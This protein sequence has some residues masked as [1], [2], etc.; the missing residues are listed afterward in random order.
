VLKGSGWLT[1][2]AKTI[3]F[4]KARALPERGRSRGATESRPQG[5]RLEA[6]FASSRSI[7]LIMSSLKIHSNFAQKLSI[8]FASGIYVQVAKPCLKKRT[9]PSL[10]VYYKCRC[11]TRR[12]FL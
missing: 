11:I 6:G 8:V 9:S 10:L 1:E 4:G 5:L 2:D 12:L 3:V 7:R